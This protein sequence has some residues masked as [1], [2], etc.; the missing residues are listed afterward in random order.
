MGKSL[1]EARRGHLGEMINEVRE[2]RGIWGNSFKRL[3][4]SGK[5]GETIGRVEICR[6]IVA[7]GWKILGKSLQESLELRED[8]E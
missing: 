4:E 1:Q 5:F 2:V 6:E 7:T 3:E 8:V